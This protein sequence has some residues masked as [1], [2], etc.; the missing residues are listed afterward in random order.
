[1]NTRTENNLPI[2]H[3]LK[4][5]YAF[6]LIISGLMALASIAGILFPSTLYPTDELLRNFLSNDVVNLLIGLPIMLISILLTIRKKLLGL[7][8]WP[9]SLLFV[10][11]NYMIYILA[12][13]LNWAVLLYLAL[14]TLSLY[15]IMKLLTIIDGK[16]IQHNLTGVVHE[17]ISGAILFAMGLLFMLQAIGAMIEPVINQ[18][19]ITRLELAVH[20]S[21]FLISPALVIGGILL[22]RRREF[23]YVSGLALLFQASMLFIGLIVFLI[24][25]PL[26]TTSP[27]LLVDV[28]VV[29]IMGLICFIPLALFIRGIMVKGNSSPSKLQNNREIFAP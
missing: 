4:I 19:H 13:P 8:L 11:Y 25:Q 6:S 28:L 12:I 23:G 20:V 2:K 18:V 29:C 14:I 7:L 1:V 10:I 17:R 21:D 15:T 9:G 3:N 5:I 27:F 24:V 22:W 16:K 26:L